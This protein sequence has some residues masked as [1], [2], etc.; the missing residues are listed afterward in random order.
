MALGRDGM[1]DLAWAEGRRLG[2]PFGVYPETKHPSSDTEVQLFQD[3]RE[4]A[5]AL[6]NA[7]LY[8]RVNVVNEIP[9]RALESGV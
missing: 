2:R 3:D 8:G 6:I 7:N 1:L 9:P 5:V 4:A